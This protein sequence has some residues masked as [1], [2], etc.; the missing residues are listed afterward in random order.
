VQL[1][2]VEEAAELFRAGG[3]SQLT[4]CLRLDLADALTG[5]VELLA[6]LL[7]ELMGTEEVNS[8]KLVN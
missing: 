6:D 8:V 1:I 3:V 2:Q 7:Q 5:D 4:E